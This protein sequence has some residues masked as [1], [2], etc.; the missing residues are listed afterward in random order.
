MAGGLSIPSGSLPTIEVDNN[1][2]SIEQRMRHYDVPGL[3]IAL[4]KD[5]KLA[6]A[7]ALGNKTK[8][9]L[10]PVRA[11]SLFQA[12]SIS[13]P[14]TAIAILQLVESG[15]LSLDKPV[16]QLLS[17]W[18]I[19]S[20]E[21]TENTPVL[22]RH[23]LNHTAGLTV[24]GFLGYDMEDEIPDLQKILNGEQPANSGR[25]YVNQTV[26]GS[27]SYRYS[28]GGYT[29]LQQLLEDRFTSNFTQYIKD[30]VFSVLDLKHSTFEQPL[31]E[32]KFSQIA[33]GFPQG[34]VESDG[35]FH[36]YP[37]QAAA[38]LWTTAGELA[39]IIIDLQKSLNDG[40]GK[41]LTQES[42]ELMI[43]PSVY[44][45]E[46]LRVF[47]IGLGLFIDDFYFSHSG[48]NEGYTSRFIAHKEKGYG[49]VVLTNANRL[50]LVN[51]IITSV[52]KSEG[53]DEF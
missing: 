15:Q 42:A 9:T 3:S 53:W 17:S 12:A 8:S 50:E 11:D 43:Q 46:H 31:P 47:G 44:G 25:V 18:K 26:G 29:V 27:Y 37:E 19:P 30:N 45:I 40:S 13:K 36:I 35:G 51:E 34:E 5:Y 6:W 10:S 39:A 2:F 48:G 1:V 16:N 41:L 4:I 28:G 22:V 33:W 23:L 14:V 21:Y 24:D 38:G 49:L 52:V 20:N 32:T 7:K